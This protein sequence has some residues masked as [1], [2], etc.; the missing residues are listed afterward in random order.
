MKLKINSKEKE[1]P[2]SVNLFQ[3]LENLNLP[4]TRGIALAVNLEVIHKTNWESYL[5][6][7]GDS[8]TLL[9]AVQGG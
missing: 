8:I 3:I 4:T 2:S 7:E 5:P 9:Q 1:F 6:V